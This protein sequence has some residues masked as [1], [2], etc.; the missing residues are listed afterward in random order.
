MTILF[1]ST[2]VLD[3]AGREMMTNFAVATS[4]HAPLITPLCRF[5][6]PSPLLPLRGLIQAVALSARHTCF[7]STSSV[8]DSKFGALLRFR[9]FCFVTRRGRFVRYTWVVLI[10]WQLCW[11]FSTVCHVVVPLGL[12]HNSRRGQTN[13]SLRTHFCFGYS[14]HYILVAVWVQCRR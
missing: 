10:E 4:A 9:K 13:A 1:A 6:L 2:S 8:L 3:P 14:L 11:T 7:P 12:A 5:F